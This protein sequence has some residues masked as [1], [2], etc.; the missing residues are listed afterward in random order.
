MER[1]RIYHF[2][3]QQDEKWHTLKVG[4]FS[5]SEIYRLFGAPTKKERATE[6][7]RQKEENIAFPFCFSKLNKSIIDNDYMNFV[8][9]ELNPNL[10]VKD[11]SFQAIKKDI[12]EW[13]KTGSLALSE[14]QTYIDIIAGIEQIEMLSSSAYTYADEKAQE[15]IYNEQDIS[16]GGFAI[17]WGNDNE[18]F[19]AH[20]FSQRNLYNAD[21]VKMSF[22]KVE[23]LETGS[24]PDDTQNR[25]TPSEYKCPFSKKIHRQHTEIEN[26]IDLLAFDKQKYYQIHHQIYV[27]MAEK[28]YWSS[29]DPRLLK[30][31]KTAAKALHTVEVARN[32]MLC[33]QFETKVILATKLRDKIVSDFMD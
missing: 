17:E 7:I 33:N 11:A 13:V 24:S 25:T 12:K 26:D 2:G 29:F 31:P 20:T 8:F 23:G 14:T 1:K 10:S 30:N 4:I 16:G 21:K 27:L 9:K 19:A 3:A 28:G 32:E 6:V 18:P 5:S 22:C 15:I